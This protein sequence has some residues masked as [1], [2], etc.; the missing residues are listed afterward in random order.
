[1]FGV[2]VLQFTNWH[3]GAGE[4][5][6]VGCNAKTPA[7]ELLAAPGGLEVLQNLDRVVGA[8]ETL[9]SRI[10]TG[11]ALAPKPSVLVRDAAREELAQMRA[12]SAL[13]GPKVAVV[14]GVAG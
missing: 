6:E 2:P 8:L 11:E 9:S 14:G 5:D 10:G 12:A 13:S 1:M 4:V 7:T 3:A